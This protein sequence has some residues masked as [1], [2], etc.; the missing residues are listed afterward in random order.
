MGIAEDLKR[1]A[2][3]LGSKRRMQ[4]NEDLDHLNGTVGAIF[5][6]T[7]FVSWMYMWA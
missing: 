3:L 7:H 2:E 5:N 1:T 6:C 4:D